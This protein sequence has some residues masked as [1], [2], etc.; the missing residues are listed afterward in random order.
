[1][2][3]GMGVHLLMEAKEQHL[4]HSSDATHTFFFSLQ[5]QSLSIVLELNSL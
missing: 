5:E 1:M 3:R 2:C 4:E